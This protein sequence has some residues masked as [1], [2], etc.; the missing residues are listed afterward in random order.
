MLDPRRNA[1]SSVLMPIG[2]INAADPARLMPS[3]GAA[4]STSPGVVRRRP[5][6]GPMPTIGIK[7]ARLRP[8]PQIKHQAGG[9][10]ERPPQAAGCNPAPVAASDRARNSSALSRIGSLPIG[11]DF[12][13][14]TTTSGVSP[15]LWIQRLFGVSQRATVSRN[16]PPS[17][18]QLLPLLDGALAERLSA[19]TSVARPVSCRAPG[20]DLAGRR[21]PAVDE[22]D[23]PDR[24]VGRDPAGRARRSAIWSP[25]GVLLPEDRPGRR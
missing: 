12:G 15:T 16:A 3:V 23:D 2:G 19:P 13:T 8:A 22:H 11:G 4:P 6:A 21:A 17:P 1:R 25:V 7:R 18:V 5:A 20:D 14:V 10:N 24:R 9:P